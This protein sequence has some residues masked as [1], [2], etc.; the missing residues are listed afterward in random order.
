VALLK[1]KKGELKQH[2]I[3]GMRWGIRRTDKQLAQDTASRKASGEDVTKTKKSSAI[4]PGTKAITG[5]ESSAQ[6]YARLT[7]EAKGGGA[8]N[9]SDADLKFYNSRTEA[10]AKVDKMFETQPSWLKSTSKKVLQ[11]AAQRTMQDIANGVS[12]KYISGPILENLNKQATNSGA[13]KAVTKAAQAA[14]ESAVTQAA[15]KSAVTQAAPKSAVTPTVTTPRK[16]GLTEEERMDQIRARTRAMNN[17]KFYVE[18]P[19][20]TALMK[21]LDEARKLGYL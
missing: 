11:N 12:T 18:R 9:W 15:P 8:T 10:M 13:A 17:A 19:D 6:R 4:S 7:G 5:E 2:G 3:R 16:L 20:T 14:P 1:Q 21:E